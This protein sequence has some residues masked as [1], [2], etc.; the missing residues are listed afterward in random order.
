MKRDPLNPTHPDRSQPILMRPEPWYVPRMP[1]P[2]RNTSQA[3]RIVSARPTTSKAWSTPRSVSRRTRAAVVAEPDS[4]TCVAPRSSASL[5]LRRVAVYCDERRGA[6]EACC[7]DDLETDSATADHRHAL[8]ALY[9]G[10]VPH[11]A[12]ARRDAASSTSSTRTAVPGS[13]K[14][15]AR[16]FIS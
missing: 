2:G 5:E 16:I 1:P 14:T 8:A 7:R 4:T 15:A 13:R 10:G 9:T 12:E 3:S 6:G 11:G